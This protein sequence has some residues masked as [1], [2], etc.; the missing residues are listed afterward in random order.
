MEKE[1]SILELQQQLDAVSAPI[2]VEHHYNKS[3]EWDFVEGDSASLDH[4]FS[5]LERSKKER[6]QQIKEDYHRSVIDSGAMLDKA[7]LKRRMKTV[8][9]YF[10]LLPTLPFR[11]Y[12]NICLKQLASQMQPAF[13]KR[14]KNY[15]G[16]TLDDYIAS[17]I[18][19]TSMRH[20]AVDKNNLILYLYL[21]NTVQDHHCE[22]MSLATLKLL[23]EFPK[24][25]VKAKDR[26]HHGV[27]KD[28]S[29][30]HLLEWCPIGHQEQ[31]C[32]SR[33]SIGNGKTLAM[34]SIIETTE[35]MENVRERAS[36]LM[37]LMDPVMYTTYTHATATA[38]KA[39]SRLL[40]ACKRDVYLGCVINTGRVCNHR[41]WSDVFCGLST[42]TPLG[43]FVG[44]DLVFP[45]LGVRLV[46][47]PGTI[48]MCSTQAI[49]HCITA[50]F[51]IRVGTVHCSHED[52]VFYACNNE[53]ED[54]CTVAEPPRKKRKK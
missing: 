26:R 48:V 49:E 37:A 35:S 17:Q 53:Q 12:N 29:V 19:P 21:P 34:D 41:D 25:F 9:H 42:M 22:R 5:H 8:D 30:Y 46:Y 1:V 15:S 47:L 24:Q 36:V 33:Q 43:H 18:A 28:V 38:T 3:N 45:Q 51:G 50:W 52:R 11:R 32:V 14:A 10:K 39:Y 4:P 13:K 6:L 7:K 40:R 54:E 20:V 2:P 16:S 31:R 27:S 44:G 23:L